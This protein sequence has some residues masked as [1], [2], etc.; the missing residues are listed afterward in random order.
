L[1]DEDLYTQLSIFYELVGT[2]GFEEMDLESVYVRLFPFSLA[3]LAKEW[4]NPT[5]TTP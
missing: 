4:L 5:P 2:M 3:G 1:D